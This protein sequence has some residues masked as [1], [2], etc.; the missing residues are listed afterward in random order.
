MGKVYRISLS[1][2][3]SLCVLV[4]AA[5][6][7]SALPA[8]AGGALKTNADGLPMR[9]DTTVSLNPE[10]GALKPGVIDHAASVAMVQAALDRWLSVPNISLMTMMGD[11]LSDGGDTHGGNYKNFY[12]SNV[13][14]CYDEDPSTPCVSPLIFDADGSIMEDIFGECTQFSIVGFAG[15]S[16]ISGESTDPALTILKRG[17]AIFNGACIAPAIEKPGCPPCNRV[18]SQTEAEAFITHEVGHLLGLGHSQ[19]NGDSYETCLQNGFC[20]EEMAEHIPTMHPYLV[21][22]ANM[23]TLHRDDEVSMQRLYGDPGLDHCKVSGQVLNEGGAPMRGVEVVARNTNPDL[24]FTDAISYVSGEEAPRVSAFGKT[25]DN[26]LENCGDFEI[27]G[28]QAGQTYQLCVS[29]LSDKF[30]GTR[31]V[32]PV[33]PPRQDF[34]NDCP[35]GLTFTCECSGANCSEFTGVNLTTHNNGV[36]Y[37]FSQLGE[38]VPRAS[39]CSLIPVKENPAWPIFRKAFLKLI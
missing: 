36:D 24:M 9:W 5:V 34:D 31:F 25:A 10:Q 27:A 18:L 20:P 37:S 33:D 11:P 7:L 26:C 23:K 30:T 4:L 21:P 16:D 39:G 22:G 15:F 3:Q 12:N 14:N 32:A 29:R 8:W 19:V 6:A 2:R 28:L 38:N 35:E 17:Y 1:I 13:M